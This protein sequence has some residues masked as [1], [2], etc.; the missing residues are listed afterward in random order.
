VIGISKADVPRLREVL[1]KAIEEA[2]SIVKSSMD[3]TVFSYTIDLFG[4]T[5]KTD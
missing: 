3:E 1:V 5:R 4:L 2:R